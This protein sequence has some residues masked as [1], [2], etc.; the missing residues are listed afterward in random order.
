MLG[1]V[2][3]FHYMKLEWGKKVYCPACTM[4]FYSM[5][6]VSLICPNCGSKFELTDL[7]AKKGANIAMDEVVDTDD[8]IALPGFEFMDEH[9]DVGLGEDTDDLSSDE[10]MDDIKLVDGE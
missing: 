9:P 10:V 2:L 7:V 8:R 1:F 6:K 4:P 3:V 5:Q